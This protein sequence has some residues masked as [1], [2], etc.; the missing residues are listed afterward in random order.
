MKETEKDNI[1]ELKYAIAKASLV[2]FVIFIF[3]VFLATSTPLK[4]AMHDLNNQ[5]VTNIVL[6][7]F[8]ITL[9]LSG[10]EI[11]ISMEALTKWEKD[12]PKVS[13]NIIGI[14]CLLLLIVFLLI[15]DIPPAQPP[16]STVYGLILTALTAIGLVFFIPIGILLFIVSLSAKMSLE[17]RAIFTLKKANT[18]LDNIDDIDQE[19]TKN[20]ERYVYLT[21]KNIKKKIGNLELKSDGDLTLDVEYT[22]FNLLPYYF[23]LADKEELESLKKNLEPMLE[24][25]NEKDKIDWRSLTPKLL[26]LNSGIT[27]YLKEINFNVATHKLSRQSQWIREIRESK[28]TL[29][30]IISIIAILAT[31]AA[32]ILAIFFHNTVSI[33]MFSIH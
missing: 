28:D 20:L 15:F 25:V 21:Y 19:D 31:I 13:V 16:T 1:M 3:I 12:Y 8:L 10:Y 32:I 30:I 18:I 22:F 5:T 17:R 27:N 23:K 7:S 4:S 14:G 29:Q 24:S 9:V 2:S 33:N 6:L 26:G 11:K